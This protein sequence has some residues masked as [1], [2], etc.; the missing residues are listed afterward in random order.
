MPASRGRATDS[1]PLGGGYI[2][3]VMGDG[4]MRPEAALVVLAVAPAFV[5]KGDAIRLDTDIGSILG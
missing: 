2:D 5:A 4:R 1:R 3:A